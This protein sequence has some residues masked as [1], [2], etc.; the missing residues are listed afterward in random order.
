M[1]FQLQGGDA[2]AN[3]YDYQ[4]GSGMDGFLSRSIDEVSWQTNLGTTYTSLSSL[5]IGQMPTTT[6]PT[7][8]DNTQISGSQSGTTTVGGSSG[9][10][11]GGSGSLQIDATNNVI[12]L[13]DGTNDRLLLGQQAGGF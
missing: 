8:Y 13:N 10:S 4:S 2:S 9:G 1:S 3:D 11:A 7:N 5:P 12:T 6:T